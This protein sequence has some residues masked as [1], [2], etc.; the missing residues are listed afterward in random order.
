MLHRVFNFWSRW[1]WTLPTFDDQNIQQKIC[2]WRNRLA[3]KRPTLLP[4]A[5]RDPLTFSCH[6]VCTAACHRILGHTNDRWLTKDF[7]GVLYGNRAKEEIK[8]AQEG[9]RASN[10]L[11][12]VLLSEASATLQSNVELSKT[13][14]SNLA[15]VQLPTAYHNPPPPPRNHHRSL[16]PCLCTCSQ[17]FK[18][19]FILGCCS[20]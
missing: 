15:C 18:D 3:H 5:L 13:S 2:T 20:V 6:T 8:N 1:Y 19:I 17:H 10:T 7:S 12:L 16:E 14:V 11:Q 9:R 4:I